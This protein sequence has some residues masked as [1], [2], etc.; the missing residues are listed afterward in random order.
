MQF[1]NKY[2]Y[3]FLAIIFIVLAWQL[4]AM[5]MKN[6]LI[7]PSPGRILVDFFTLVTSTDFYI[8]L[9]STLLRGFIGFLIAFVLAAVIGIPAGIFR[10]FHDFFNPIIVLL[11]ST[12]VISFILLAWIWFGP[13]NVPVFI[14]ILSMFPLLCK[15]FISGIK[16]TDK[17]LIDMAL[18]YKVRKHRILSG[19]YIP[20]LLPFLFNGMSN[21]L[22][23]G[24]R[25]VII[26]EV[27]S[28][29]RWGLGTE[30]QV[31]QTYLLVSKLIC[32]SIVAVIMA[33]FFEWLL[34]LIER[35]S[36]RWKQ[37]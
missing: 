29:P 28:Q 25:A 6:G 34:G 22:G 17:E 11:R 1:F 10:G 19:L 15:G 20:S 12:P 35:R 30:M 33:F 9:A 4:A 2:I 13:D 5:A 37:I 14:A 23:F 32:W 8:A 7:L 3:Q 31:A 18:V 26:G 36:L 21:A 27:L 24:W 16:S